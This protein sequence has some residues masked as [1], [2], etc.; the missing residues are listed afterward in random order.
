MYF[1]I[2]NNSWIIALKQQMIRPCR[3]LWNIPLIPCKRLWPITLDCFWTTLG[4][5]V[6]RVFQSVIE[7]PCRSLGCCQGRFMEDVQS[8]G[9]ETVV[10]YA[11]HVGLPQRQ[12]IVNLVWNSWLILLTRENFVVHPAWQ[13]CTLSTVWPLH[14]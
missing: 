5:V 8:G 11:S 2:Q 10:R 4:R 7:Q 13:F 12:R 3:L 9:V 6:T 14:H 1:W